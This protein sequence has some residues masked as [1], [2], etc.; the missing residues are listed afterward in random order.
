MVLRYLPDLALT[1]VVVAVVVVVV[2][3][4]FP[5]LGHFI[6]SRTCTKPKLKPVFQI[7]FT[8][9]KPEFL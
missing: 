7:F 4:L 9:E 2:V 5:S 3:V 6:S 1:E 8:G